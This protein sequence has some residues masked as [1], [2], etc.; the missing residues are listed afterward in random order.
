MNELINIDNSKEFTS[1]DISEWTGK[2]HNH[3]LRDIR[4]EIEKLGEI[5]HDLFKLVTY[6]SLY[7][8]NIIE[9]KEYKMSL[10]GLLQITARY[11]AKVRF[12]IICKALNISNL[13]IDSICMEHSS[14]NLEGN[15]GKFTKINMEG[16]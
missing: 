15:Y 16:E 8:K 14:N 4:N 6:P 11:N 13:H 3:V 5:G 1:K 10:I 9:R 12:N 2:K 7:H